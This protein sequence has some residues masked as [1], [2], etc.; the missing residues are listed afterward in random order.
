M[1]AMEAALKLKGSA[2]SK[3]G[4]AVLH[5]EGACAVPARAEPF[6]PLPVS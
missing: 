2:P 6:W 3:K 1:E 4:E 5:K